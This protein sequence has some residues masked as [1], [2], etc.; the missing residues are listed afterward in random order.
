MT[1][2]AIWLIILF[3]TLLMGIMSGPPVMFAIAGVPTLVALAAAAFGDFD[4]VLMQAI[5]QRV[6]GIMENRLF[7]AVPLF[8]LMGILL[9]RSGQAE[10]KLS[11]INAL[12]GRRQTGLALALLALSALIAA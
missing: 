3:V 1:V 10:R 8:V 12:F 9:D 6:F 11:S 2:E 7:L 4:L 5:P